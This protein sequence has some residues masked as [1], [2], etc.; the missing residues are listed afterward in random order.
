MEGVEKLVESD[1]YEAPPAMPQLPEFLRPTQ[2]SNDVPSQT[3]MVPPGFGL[4]PPR[5]PPFMPFFTSSSIWG[6]NPPSLSHDL[7]SQRLDN[8]QALG[9]DSQ[10]SRRQDPY[11]PNTP[12]SSLVAVQNELLQQQKEI[13]NRSSSQYGSTWTPPS[14]STPQPLWGR[15]QLDNLPSYRTSLL[16]NPVQPPPGYDFPSSHNDAFIASTISS[17]HTSHRPQSTQD[18][19][20]RF[21]TIGQQT[22]PCGQAG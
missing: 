22:P 10:L 21:G 4:A 16:Q 8:A 14:I 6:P 20:T 15:S 12:N 9:P 3:P 5:S 19:S 7:S 18:S 17:H 1:T 11:T 13:E 2:P